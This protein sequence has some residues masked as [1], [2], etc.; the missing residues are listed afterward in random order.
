MKIKI[1]TM[2]NAVQFQIKNNTICKYDIYFSRILS[3]KNG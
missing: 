1:K 2:E 3:R